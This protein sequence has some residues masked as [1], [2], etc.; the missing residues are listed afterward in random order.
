[1]GTILRVG[2]TGGIGS[3]K[4]TV[5]ALLDGPGFMIIDADRLG[6]AVLDEDEQARRELVEALG[7]EILDA[8]GRIDRGRL[9]KLVFADAA[10]RER[11]ERIVHPRIRA[12]EEDRV[13]AWGVPTGIAVT[14]A[15]LLVETGG[16]ERY[17]AL[18]VVTADPE[19]R[20]DRLQ[21][22]GLSR[23]ES[24]R[25]MAAQLDD[26]GA[27]RGGRLRDRQ[28]RQQRLHRRAGRR[29]SADAARP[30]GVG[31]SGLSHREIDAGVTPHRDTGDGVVLSGVHRAKLVEQ[32]ARHCR[33]SGGTAAEFGSVLEHGA[34]EPGHQ[35]VGLL[36]QLPEIHDDGDPVEPL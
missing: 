12:A 10:A 24:E 23:A 7:E 33:R 16:R 20:I 19:V 14:E 31:R 25:R 36:T 17:D 35:F 15:A 27:R 5:A 21:R 18:V 34:L 30:A 8:A 29:P 3:G 2:L 1:M 4:S 32:P 13:D 26:E 6:H 9:G 28:Q 11:L 22:R